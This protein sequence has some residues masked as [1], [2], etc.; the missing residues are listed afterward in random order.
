MWLAQVGLRM[1][2]ETSS[3][4]RTSHDKWC[5]GKKHR[6]CREVA[7]PRSNRRKTEF[8]ILCYITRFRIRAIIRHATVLIRPGWKLKGK[9]GVDIG[10]SRYMM[11][12][13]RIWLEVGF[14]LEY[15]W[16]R[17][18]RDKQVSR[19]DRGRID[20]PRPDIDGRSNNILNLT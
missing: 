13:R 11:T 6:E 5:L 12:K 17:T 3:R 18:L 10:D 20:H 2:S 9:M 1:L 14:K 8:A 19:R 15:Y 16:L 7:A 4:V